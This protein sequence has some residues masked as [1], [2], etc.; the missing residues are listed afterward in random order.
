[1]FSGSKSYRSLVGERSVTVA[2]LVARTYLKCHNF[3]NISLYRE[4][5]QFSAFFDAYNSWR[6]REF[7]VLAL[8]DVSSTASDIC[9]KSYP[10]WINPVTYSS[11][12]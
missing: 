3:M 11:M 6:R 12:V 10:A 1:M 8:V 4:T 7:F 2:H 9:L 5:F